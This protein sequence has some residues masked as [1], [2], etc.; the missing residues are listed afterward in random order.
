MKYR[1]CHTRFSVREGDREKFRLKSVR[2]RETRRQTNRQTDR[3]YGRERE[4]GREKQG[5]RVDF[6]LSLRWYLPSVDNVSLSDSTEITRF[7]AGRDK[8]PSSITVS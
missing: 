5:D 7:M 3:N 2:R 4:R 8:A 6:L 1:L